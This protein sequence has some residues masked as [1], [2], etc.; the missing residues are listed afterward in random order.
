MKDRG[1]ELYRVSRNP[2]T[3]TDQLYVTPK[4]RVDVITSPPT[5]L[6]HEGLL[7]EAGMLESHP[8]TRHRHRQEY[9]ENVNE[10]LWNK[11][12]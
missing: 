1:P 6:A 3:D 4:R 10:R 2:S 5:D 8:E 12:W 11:V 7:S 9:D